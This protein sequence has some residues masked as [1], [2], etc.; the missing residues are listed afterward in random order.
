MWQATKIITVNI[1]LSIKTA[2][3][4]EYQ[5]ALWDTQY[6]NHSNT[7]NPKKQISTAW[8]SSKAQENNSGNA[9][10]NKDGGHFLEIYSERS[11]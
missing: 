6:Q 1:P 3:D 8:I 7:F 4:Q 5:M 9:V 10:K 11:S 2:E